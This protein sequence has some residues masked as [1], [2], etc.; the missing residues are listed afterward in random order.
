[1]GY[2]AQGP[3]PAPRGEPN[4]RAGRIGARVGW[5][6]AMRPLAIL[7]GSVCM[8]HSLHRVGTRAHRRNIAP[9]TFLLFVKFFEWLVIV[10]RLP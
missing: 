4:V 8:G 9:P 1:M 3:L 5:D 6:E 10:T 2:R 7:V